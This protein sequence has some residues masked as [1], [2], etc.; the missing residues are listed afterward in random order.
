MAA[1]GQY[2]NELPEVVEFLVGDELIGI[3]GGVLFRAP[4]PTLPEGAAPVT[5]V[6]NLTSTSTTD[7]LSA[8]QGNAL[9]A[10]IDT[11]CPLVGGKVPSANLPSYVDDVLEYA[12]FASFPVTGEAGKIYV[13]IS[14]DFVYRWSGSAYFQLGSSGGGSGIREDVTFSATALASNATAINTVNI[15]SRYQLLQITTNYP[16]RVRL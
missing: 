8:K 4:T 15:T 5:V 9:K 10:E 13:D 3:R 6:D 11:K 2:P 16:C 7:A 14:T 12:N 1:S